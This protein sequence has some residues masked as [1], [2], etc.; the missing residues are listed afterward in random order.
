MRVR[1]VN[2]PNRLLTGAF[3]PISGVR[4]PGKNPGS[5]QH[6]HHAL[7][8]AAIGIAARW[9]LAMVVR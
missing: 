4:L 2:G 7:G 6:V 9:L 8:V 5:A 1:L 3:R